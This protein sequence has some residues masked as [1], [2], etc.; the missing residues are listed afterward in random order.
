ME[1]RHL[2]AD[3]PQVL[4]AWGPT[5]IPIARITAD[6]RQVT[7]GALFVAYRGVGADGHRFIADALAR[8]ARAV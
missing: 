3:L 4:A 6:S 5:D 8:G 2:A 1:L 7:P